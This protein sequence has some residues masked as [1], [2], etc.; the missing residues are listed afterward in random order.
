M[1]WNE[2]NG[3][4]GNGWQISIHLSLLTFAQTHF[5]RNGKI[6]KERVENAGT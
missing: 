2:W 1:E 6:E 4:T 3:G 5:L